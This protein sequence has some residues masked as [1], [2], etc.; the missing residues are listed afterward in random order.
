[1]LVPCYCQLP[2]SLLP[3]SISITGI[4]SIALASYP[5]ISTSLTQV[6]QVLICESHFSTQHKQCLI[7]QD[8]GLCY[9]PCPPHSTPR[10]IVRRPFLLSW[11]IAGLRLGEAVL[12]LG[13][14]S[15]QHRRPWQRG[16]GGP[17]HGGSIPTRYVVSSMCRKVEYSPELA[18]LIVVPRDKLDEVVVEG[19]TCL[20]IENGRTG[21]TVQVRGDNLVLGV[22]DDTLVLALSSGLDRGLDV[23]VR[24]TLLN[25]ALESTVSHELRSLQDRSL[26]SSQQRRRSV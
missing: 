15:C 23:L 8:V 5:Q 12:E 3:Y 6:L 7:F 21:V 18:Y 1:L 14:F 2:A 9:Y 10:R 24:G 19:D 20:G 13:R 25:A 17:R 16:R 4:F 11:I 22:S 26:Q